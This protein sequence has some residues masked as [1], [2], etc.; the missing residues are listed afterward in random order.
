MFKLKIN[1]FDILPFI[2]G[3]VILTMIFLNEMN[4]RGTI[5]LKYGFQYMG[6]ILPVIMALAV[7]N[8][9]KKI[10]SPDGVDLSGLTSTEDIRTPNFRYS[11]SVMNGTD[12]S[13]IKVY[14]SEKEI[15][16]YYRNFFPIKMYNGPFTICK[17]DSFCS[18]GFMVKEF[19][20]TGAREAKLSIQ[21]QSGLTS[22][23][24]YLKNVSEKDLQLMQDHFRNF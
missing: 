18:S 14:F 13:F 9:V 1:N 3:A 17:R 5:Q 19:E 21:S 7:F 12:V 8:Y 11:G 20:K 22:Y 2:L 15:Y 4:A 24:F 16:V 6:H 23:S 10:N